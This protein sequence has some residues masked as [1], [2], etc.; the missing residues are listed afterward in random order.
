MKKILTVG[1]GAILILGIVIIGLQIKII[2]EHKLVDNYPQVSVYPGAVL[3]KSS[4]N[5]AQNMLF[6]ADWTSSDKVP[7]IMTWYIDALQK[8][9]WKLD[10]APG[11]R[12]SETIQYAEFT[13]GL[14]N[15]WLSKMQLSIDTNK[16]THSSNIEISFPAPDSEHEE[17]N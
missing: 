5:D 8:E 17:G 14:F 6:R 1:M 3:Q 11:D 12:N 10:I 4:S 16:N 15:S 9:G 7:Q 2:T 13:K